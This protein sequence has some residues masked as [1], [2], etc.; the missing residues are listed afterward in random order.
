MLTIPGPLAAALLAAATAPAALAQTSRVAGCAPQP[1]VSRSYAVPMAAPAGVV[2]R[3]GERLVSGAPNGVVQTAYSRPAYVQSR[4]PQSGVVRTGYMQQPTFAQQPAFPQ[5]AQRQ[6][7]QRQAP[8]GVGG[9][10]QQRAQAEANQ[11][12]RTGNRGHVGGTIGRFEG[13][14]WAM[15]GTPSTCTPGRGMTLTADAI[16]RGPGGVYR[17]RAWR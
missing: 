17:V 13:V 12:A 3:P 6:P 10:D 11:M 16:A 15:S 1:F 14:G 5:P 2:L 8:A 7:T 9:S 4:P